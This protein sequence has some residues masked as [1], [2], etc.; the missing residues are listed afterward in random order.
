M[1]FTLKMV[2]VIPRRQAVMMGAK[3]WPG[4]GIISLRTEYGSK[5]KAW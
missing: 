3:L 5:V 4:N 1:Q 2:D